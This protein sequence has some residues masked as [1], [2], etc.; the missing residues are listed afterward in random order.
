MYIHL[1]KAFCLTTGILSLLAAIGLSWLLLF[2]E[3]PKRK[4]RPNG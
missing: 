1:L 2:P 3:Y 4:S